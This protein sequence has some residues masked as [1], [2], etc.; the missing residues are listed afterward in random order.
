MPK[1]TFCGHA[2]FLVEAGSHRALIDPF[3]TGNP[4][5][6]H[7]VDQIPKVSAIVVSH[8]HGDHLGD[9]VEIAKRDDAPVVA[10]FELA[11]FC[12]QQGVER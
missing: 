6:S 10:T 8:G 5:A 11:S 4:A 2:C 9:S 3:L 12:Q 7:T 1:L